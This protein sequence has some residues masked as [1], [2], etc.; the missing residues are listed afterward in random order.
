VSEADT[1]TQAA[2]PLWRHPRFTPYWIGY[3]VSQF[4]DRITEL[5]LPLIAVLTPSAGPGETGLL[6]AVIW[7]PNLLAVL[8]GSW[9]ERT[10][11][12]K[13]LLIT[14]DLLRAAVLV[15]LPVGY[16]L[17]AVTL[18]QLLVVALLSGVGQ[19][20]FSTAYPPFFV[21]LIPRSQYINA[22]SKL[23]GSRA[24]SFVA[25]PALS[26]VLIQVLTAPIAVL[27]DCASFVVSAALIGHVRVP[28]MPAE[29]AVGSI[30]RNAGT[31]LKYVSHNRYLRSGL[32]C[33]ATVNYFNFISTALVVLFAARSLHLPAAVIGLAFGIGALG[34]ILGAIISPRLSRRFGIGHMIV[35]GTVVFPAPTAALAF[36]GGPKT[37]CAVVLS[38]A[39][40]LSS[41]GVMFLDINY[42]S[43]RSCVIPDRLRSRVAG[44]FTT[45]NYGVR[46]LGAL[47][48]AALG[49]WLGL[50]P[51]LLVAA[52]GGAL[53]V[54]WLYPS[55]IPRLRS[56]DELE[57]AEAA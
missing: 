4:G 9:V 22:N 44:A 34:G 39:E 51:T 7:A 5:A 14:A 54:L 49:R 38:A 2:T 36:A 15:S 29:P 13:A 12:K 10:T 24:A 27:V 57:P 11:R 28:V 40:F 18:T 3:T 20:L 19:V 33:F 45:I 6:T 32:C 8:V 46:P 43:L 1:V 37:L 16:L 23:N 30:W 41:I 55:P 35:L 17:A 21:R 42:S 47:T 25:G 50:R 53:S 48:G 26:G 52:V 56:L 31:G